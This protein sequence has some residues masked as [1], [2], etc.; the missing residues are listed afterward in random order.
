MFNGLSSE[1]NGELSFAVLSFHELFN[2]QPRRTQGSHNSSKPPSL[3]VTFTILSHLHVSNRIVYLRAIYYEHLA[4]YLSP[5]HASFR[6]LNNKRWSSYF[7]TTR[8]SYIL[9]A[10]LVINVSISLLTSAV[11]YNI[12][13]GAFV[14]N[15][16]WLSWAHPQSLNLIKPSMAPA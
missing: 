16:R 13:S 14:H 8:P 6:Y 15:C 3:R 1:R 12:S 7:I 5:Y 11:Q 9:G 10:V 4:A 2:A